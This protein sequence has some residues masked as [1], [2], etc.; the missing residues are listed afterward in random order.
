MRSFR[1]F[2]KEA[3]LLEFKEWHQFIKQNG[4]SILKMMGHGERYATLAGETGH[5]SPQHMTDYIKTNLG[6]ADASQEHGNW[7]LKKLHAGKISNMEDIPT[8][9]LRNLR[10]YSEIKNRG[11]TDVELKNIN[12]PD[13]LYT[14]VSKHDTDTMDEKL[15]LEEGKDYTLLGEN[16]HWYVYRPHTETAACGLGKNTNWCTTYGR[17]DYYN[18]QGPLTIFIPKKP[19]YQNEK[20][21][22]HL[23]SNQFTDFNDKEIHSVRPGPMF[24]SRPLPEL[25]QETMKRLEDGLIHD[26]F[27]DPNI[28]EQDLLKLLDH[29]TVMNSPLKYYRTAIKSNSEAV[30]KKILERTINSLED[31]I[32]SAILKAGIL[33]EHDSVALPSLENFVKMREDEIDGYDELDEHMFASKN[34]KIAEYALNKF[35][36]VPNTPGI[37]LTTKHPLIRH[38]IPRH[39]LPNIKFEDIA[40]KFYDKMDALDNEGSLQIGIDTGRREALNS[41]FESIA[42]RALEQNFKNKSVPRQGEVG[43]LD[44]QPILIPDRSIKEYLDSPHKSVALRAADILIPHLKVDEGFKDSHIKYIIEDGFASRHAAVAKKFVDADVFHKL[45]SGDDAEYL[46]EMIFKSAIL[47]TKHKDVARKFIADPRV[48]DFI[49]KNLGYNLRIFLNFSSQHNQ[50]KEILG[51]D[52]IEKHMDSIL[53]KMNPAVRGYRLNQFT[54]DLMSTHK[55]SKLPLHFINSKHFSLDGFRDS[56]IESLFYAHGEEDHGEEDRGEELDNHDHRQIAL[57][58]SK[59]MKPEMLKFAFSLGNDNIKKAV[60]NSKLMN[61]KTFDDIFEHY[62]RKIKLPP[63]SEQIRPNLIKDYKILGDNPFLNSEHISSMINHFMKNVGEDLYDRRKI[64]GISSLPQFSHTN[65]SELFLGA[66]KKPHPTILSD[67][68]LQMVRWNV[69]STITNANQIISNFKAGGVPLDEDS[70]SYLHE[71]IRRTRIENEEKTPLYYHEA[72]YSYDNLKI[73]REQINAINSKNFNPLYHAGLA[74]RS[75]FD[76]VKAHFIRSKHFRPEDIRELAGIETDRATPDQYKMATDYKNPLYQVAKALRLSPHFKEEHYE[77][78]NNSANKKLSGM[79]NS[80]RDI[81][82]HKL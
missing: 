37:H 5:G 64:E 34:R 46:R 25:D 67:T 53:S 79:L 1:L 41:P 11:L 18:E 33:S 30:G 9:I 66:H 55:D 73:M 52:L 16:E 21:Q 72:A 23:E 36:S 8:S 45:G 58:N 69:T 6:I 81:P 3:L 47:E 56:E 12:N 17:F 43:L 26:A 70:E 78:F 24:K 38:G 50:T 22:H 32:S 54:Q 62:T 14:L 65:M 68:H 74:L 49:A 29:P 63:S 48:H 44:F 71:F 59:H 42:R 51:K 31:H 7:I 61:Q 20:Y 2:L 4:A 40:H 60:I 28:G 77:L 82:D 75:P 80:M 10:K 35:M 57:I 76:T 15:G 39:V 27:S 19:A 13:E